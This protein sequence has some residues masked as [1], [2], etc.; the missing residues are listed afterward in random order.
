MNKK[1]ILQYIMFNLK[2]NYLKH[3]Y[4]VIGLP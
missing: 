4:R 2:Q 3:I 1:I